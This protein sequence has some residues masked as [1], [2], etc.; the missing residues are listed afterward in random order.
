MRLGSAHAAQA[1]G[2]RGFWQGRAYRWCAHQLFPFSIEL[3]QVGLIAGN[4]SVEFGAAGLQ[5]IL[6]LPVRH[7]QLSQRG[8]LR[9]ELLLQRCLQRAAARGGRWRRCR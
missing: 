6:T 9:L 5:R 8:R 7:S 1:G 4:S 3:V 2:Q